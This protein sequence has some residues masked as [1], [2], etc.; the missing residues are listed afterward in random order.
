MSRS[1]IFVNHQGLHA[2]TDWHRFLV[3]IQELHHG[4]LPN[5]VL[6]DDA[7]PASAAQASPF[8][9]KTV[10]RLHTR[11]DT[12][13]AFLLK[14]DQDGLLVLG[15]NSFADWQQSMQGTH[16]KKTQAFAMHIIHRRRLRIHKAGE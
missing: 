15:K 13:T 1:L 7:L 3:T 5:Q 4:T 6:I 2:P 8:A 10:H 14:D 16:S 11:A 9:H 12:V